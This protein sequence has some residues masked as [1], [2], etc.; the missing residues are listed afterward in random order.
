MRSQEGN[1]KRKWSRPPPGWVK[2]NV[3]AAIFQD[4]CIGVG[5]VLRDSQGKFMKASCTRMNGA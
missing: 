1:C 2:M 3:D 5:S 4:G